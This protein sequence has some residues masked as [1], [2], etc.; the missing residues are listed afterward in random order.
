MRVGPR[1]FDSDVSSGSPIAVTVVSFGRGAPGQEVRGLEIKV[2]FFLLQSGLD[3][4]FTFS[5]SGKAKP[6]NVH[7]VKE[8]Q[9]LPTRAHST[10]QA[11]VAPYEALQCRQRLPQAHC[12]L[13]AREKWG[14]GGSAQPGAVTGGHTGRGSVPSVL[15]GFLPPFYR[16]R[17]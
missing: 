7:A 17:H 6:G 15:L 11:A 12:L 9:S 2:F 5:P 8:P 3:V 13:L 14:E 10:S 16:W 1:R 4:K